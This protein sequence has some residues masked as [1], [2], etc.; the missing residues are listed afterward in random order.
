MSRR[1]SAGKRAFNIV[2]F[3]ADEDPSPLL[4]VVRVLSALVVPHDKVNWAH[5]RYVVRHRRR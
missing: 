1:L 3:I 5:H 2:V 4:H